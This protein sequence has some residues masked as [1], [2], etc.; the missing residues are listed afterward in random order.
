MI[1]LF[2]FRGIPVRLDFG[3]LVIFA[4][5]SWSLASGYFPDALP[6]LSRAA[7]WAQGL[8]AALLLFVSVFLHELSH[9]M[10]ALRHGVGVGSITLHVFG[11]VSQLE[12][13]PATPRAEFLIAIVGPLTSFGIAGVCFAAERVLPAPAWAAAILA[14]LSLVNAIV[15]A[16]NL[17]PGLPLD[18]GRVLRSALWAWRGQAEWATAVASNAGSAFAFLLMA[19]GLLRTFA[20]QVVGG[21]WFILIGIFLHQA[22][23]STWELARIQHRLERVPVTQ[24]MTRAPIVVP[25]TLP[26][27]RLVDEFFSRYHVA[28]FPVDDAGRLAGFITWAQVEQVA[29]AADGLVVADVMAPVDG[30]LVVSSRDSAWRAFMK[31]SRNRVGRVAVVDHGRLVGI[32]SHRDLAHVLAVEGVRTTMGDR[33]A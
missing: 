18:G 29:A 11:G 28:G 2:S 5:I 7:Y 13:E 1:R 31:I 16:F 14:Y 3:W 30:S 23:R 24:V 4:L 33:T 15:G 22:A 32:V 19:L 6:H 21:M 10:V 8:V 27:S 25:P 20:G 9:A 12:S 17:V 26:I